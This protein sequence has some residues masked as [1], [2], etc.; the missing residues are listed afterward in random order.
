M[1]QKFSEPVKDRAVRD[2]CRVTGNS[3]PAA[4][5]SYSAKILP[6]NWSDDQRTAAEVFFFTGAS[7]AYELL[8]TKAQAAGG[9]KVAARK[10]L[11][12][13]IVW[14]NRRKKVLASHV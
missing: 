6:K 12:D 14:L 11:T 4:W 5:A 7:F 10:V 9:P 1:S 3:L 13:L 8:V 2:R